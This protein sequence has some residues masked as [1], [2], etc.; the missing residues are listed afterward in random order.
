MASPGSFDGLPGGNATFQCSS[1]GGPGNNFTWMRQS[2]G[3]VI[4]NQSTLSIMDLDAFDGGQ[5]QC[6]VENRAGN[7]TTSVTLY[8]KLY[9]PPIT[10][11]IWG[12]HEF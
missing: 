7:D 4:G 6:C 11:V 3:M 5:Y 10:N 12:E 2:D 1:L 8:G 9:K